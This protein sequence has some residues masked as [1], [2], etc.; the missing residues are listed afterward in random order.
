MLLHPLTFA[1]SPLSLSSLLPCRVTKSVM[2]LTADACLT[3]DPG[4]V[5]S[6]PDW[7]HTFVEIDH[8][9]FSTVFL[10]PSANQE[11]MLSVTSESISTNWLTAWSSLLREKVWLGELTIPT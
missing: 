5:S 4:D 7:S 2:C 10:I 8:E 1:G 11:G 6:I 9:I 3:A